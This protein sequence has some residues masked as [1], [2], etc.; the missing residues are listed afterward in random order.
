[1]KRIIDTRLPLIIY[2]PQ[3]KYEKDMFIN[4]HESG[5][6][7]VLDTEHCDPEKTKDIIRELDRENI[8]FGIRVLPENN[9]VL[10]FLNNNNIIHVNIVIIVYKN[11]GMPGNPAPDNSFYKRFLEISGK[12]NPEFIEKIKPHGLILK[13]NET[14]GSA[15]EHSSLS[16]TDWYI[17]NTG[18]PLFIHGVP[19]MHTTPGLFAAGAHGIVLDN[20]L[21]S[22]EYVHKLFTNTGTCLQTVDDHD[23]VDPAMISSVR[24]GKKISCTNKISTGNTFL[25][26]LE[27]NIEEMLNMTDRDIRGKEITFSGDILNKT[28]L[29]F[30]TGATSVLAQKGVNICI[31]PDHSDSNTP[32]EK[33]LKETKLT[34]Y[35]NLNE[36]EVFSNENNQI[37]D[38]IAVIGIAGIFPDARNIDE[39]WDNIISKKYSISEVPKERFDHDLYYSTDRKA[40]DKSYSKIGGVI[41]DYKF[42]HTKFGYSEEESKY[43]SRSQK[44]MLDIA[45]KAVEDAGYNKGNQLPK[46]RSSVI[47]AECLAA[48]FNDRHYKYA[49]PEIKYYLEQ[50]DEYNSLRTEEKQV[51]L[52]NLKK[53]T[54]P[55]NPDDKLENTVV[56][57]EAS[58]I[59][60]HLGIT[61]SAYTVNA[62][63]AS[64]L[65]AVENAVSMLL[66]GDSDIVIA[67]GINTS[68]SPEIFTGFSKM[69]GLSD[70]G[71]Y[72]FDERANGFV[73]GEGAGAVILKRMKDA[74]RDKD[75]I[76]GIIKGV[77]C[78][79]DGKGRA[80]AAPNSDGQALAM[81]RCFEKI[82]TDISYDDIDYIEAHG[83][84]TTAGDAEEIKTYKN[85]YKSNSPIGISSVKSQIG[86]LLGGAGMAG[87]IK[88]L[89]AM[90]NKTLPPNGVFEN[91]SGKIK[92]EEP[93]Y[94]IKDPL[95]W[96]KKSGQS[97]KASVSSFGFGGINTHIVI[98]E[99]T[100][101]YKLLKNKIFP[102]PGYD[103]NNDRIVVAGMGCVL[104]D[105]P[106]TESFFNNLITGKKSLYP[107]PDKKLHNKYYEKEEEKY[108]LPLLKAGII[109]DYNF[110]IKS[111]RIPP[112]SL[113]HID[114]YQLY[115][116]DAAAQA[117][118]QVKQDTLN[119]GNNIG[120]ITGST[121]CGD[122]MYENVLRTRLPHILKTISETKNVIPHDIIDNINT[123]LSISI[124]ERFHASTEDTFPGHITNLISGRIANTLNCNGANYAIDAAS[125]S[126]ACAISAAI[127]GLK[128]NDYEYVLTG[129]SDSNLTP[130]IFKGFD[131]WGILSH[132]ENR[133]FE[134]RSDGFSLGEGAVMFLLTK[135]KTARKN[136]MKIYAELNDIPFYNNPEKKQLLSPDRSS[137]RNAIKKYYSKNPVTEDQVQYIEVSGIS[138]I[139]FDQFEH[140]AINT[141]F[142]K[143]IYFGN[144]KPN[145]GYLKSANPAA[146]LLKLILMSHHAYIPPNDH[147]SGNDSILNS[148]SVLKINKEGI[149]L[150]KSLNRF[151]AAN[152]FGIGGSHAHCVV[153]NL[154]L[155]MEKYNDNIK[156]Q[157]IKISENMKK[158]EKANN[159]GTN[160]ELAVML[161]G[162]GAQYP[163]MMKDLYY[164]YD[165][166]HELFN[167][168]EKI[169]T[170]IT[171]YSLLDIMFGNDPGLILTKNTQPAVF[172]VSASLYSYLEQLG[173]A[174]ACFTGHS[175]G[176]FTALF[177]S[178]ML[179]FDRA[180]RLVIKR[181]ELMQKV[182]DE[183]PGSMLAIFK[184]ATETENIINSSGI[185]NIYPANKNSDNQTIVS[186]DNTSLARFANRLKRNN[187]LHSNINVATAFHSP[188][189]A[190]ATI[191]L[192][193]YLDSIRF[194]ISGSCK[195]YSNVTALPYPD[196]ENTVKDLLASQM[197]SPVEFCNTIKN[198]SQTGIRH[199]LEVGPNNILTGL[200]K[201]IDIPVDFS[202]H[203]I[204]SKNNE[205]ASFDDLIFS[206]KNEKLIIKTQ[207]PDSPDIPDIAAGSVTGYE[208]ESNYSDDPAG[209]EQAEYR[210]FI[211]EHKSEVNRILHDEYKKY[212]EK[213]EN[214]KC[215]KYGLY[216]GDIVI[217][218]VSAG[219]PGSKREVFSDH[220][221]KDILE[222]TNFIESVTEKDKNKILDKNITRLNKSS[223]GSARFEHVQSTDEVIQLAARLGY[224]DIKEYGIDYKYD[225]TYSLALAAGIEA[226]K[227][228][229]IPLVMQYRTATTGKTVQSGYALPEEMQE[230]TGIIFSSVF[231]G[232]DSLIEE[233]SKYYASKFLKEPF[234]EYEKLYFFLMEKIS[235]TDIKRTVTDWFMELKQ[236]TKEIEPYVFK[237]NL[238]IDLANIGGSILA[239]EIRA[240]GPVIHTSAA[241]ASATHAAGIAE[242]WIRTDRCDRV[243][244]IAGED[245]AS[246]N[247]FEWIGSTF[248]SMGIGTTSKDVREA[249]VPFD[250]RRKGTIIGSAG[251]ALIIE[252][253]SEV[254]KRGL[255]GQAMILG[256]YIGNSAFHAS[257]MDV[258]DI[259]KNMKL[260]IDKMEERHGLQKDKY[261]ESMLFMSHETYTPARGGSAISEVTA[262]KHAFPMHYK[263]ITITNTKGY[264]GHTIGAGIED[265]VM[266]KSLQMKQ[267]PAIANLKDIPAEFNDLKFSNGD[268][269]NYEYALHFAAGFGSHFSMLFVKKLQEAEIQDNKQYADWLRDISGNKIPELKIINKR[270]CVDHKENNVVIYEQDDLSLPENSFEK[271]PEDKAGEKGTI[272]GNTDQETALSTIKSIISELTGYSPDMLEEDLDLEADLGI[273][274]VKQV[275]IFGRISAQFNRDLPENLKLSEYN[276]IS[277]IAGF[278]ESNTTGTVEQQED[279][280]P[281]TPAEDNIINEIKAI[282]AELTGYSE[283][284]LEHDLDLEADLGIDTVKQ[285]EIFGRISA[286][287]NR[288]LPENL[289][290]SEYNT[291]SKIAGFINSNE[292][293]QD[294]TDVNEEVSETDPAGDAQPHIQKKTIKRAIPKLCE[295]HNTDTK[296]NIFNNKTFIISVDRYGFAKELEHQINENNGKTITIGTDIHC[297]HKVDLSSPMQTEKGIKDLINKGNDIHGFI[298]LAPVDLYFDNISTEDSINTAV[299]SFFVIVKALHEKLNNKDCLISALAFNS[300]IFPYSNDPSGIYPAYAGL[301]GMMKTIAKE[302]PEALVKIVDI[303]ETVSVE[304]IDIKK[305]ISTYILELM[306]GDRMVETGYDGDK[307]Y[308]ISYKEAVP[309]NSG[310]IIKDNDT[311]LVTGGARGITFEILRSLVN[312]YKIKLVIAGKTGIRGINGFSEEYSEKEIFEVLSNKMKGARPVEIK[313][314]VESVIKQRQVTSNIEYLKTSGNEVIYEQADVTNYNDIEN[315]ISRYDFNGIIHGAGIEESSLLQNKSVDS[316]NRVFDTKVTG[317]QNLLIALKNTE[318]RYFIAFSSVAAKFGNEGQADYSSSNDMMGKILQK[319]KVA[320]PDRIFKIIDWTAWEG[321]GMADRESVKKALKDK[322]I[323]FLS[324][325]QGVKFFMDEIKDTTTEEIVISDTDT[326]TD[327][328]G[329]FRDSIPEN[330]ENNKKYILLDE[331]VF[332][333][334]TCCESTYTFSLDKDLYLNSHIIGKYPVVP[335]TFIAEIMIE[336]CKSLLPSMN[337]VRLYDLEMYHFIKLF[338]NKNRKIKIIS[339]IHN[340][341]NHEIILH[342]KIMCDVI[343]HL[344]RI[345]QKDKLHYECK[346]ELSEKNQKSYTNKYENI[347]FSRYNNVSL[348][349]KSSIYC[350]EFLF[351]GHKMQTV[352]DLIY[353][354]RRMGIAEIRYTDQNIIQSAIDPDY[355]LDPILFDACLQLGGVVAG[356]FYKKTAL[357]AMIKNVRLY[358]KIDNNSSYYTVAILKSGGFDNNGLFTSDIILYNKNWEPV[359][360]IEDFIGREVENISEKSLKKISENIIYTK[361]SIPFSIEPETTIQKDNFSL[362]D[363]KIYQ[364]EQKV[365]YSRI[366]DIKHDFFLS[367][368]VKDGI[369]LF[370]G[371]TAIEAMTQAVITRIGNDYKI[372]EIHD[373]KIPYGIK[374]LKGKPKEI[375]IEA[376]KQDGRNHEFL[377]SISTENKHHN[378]SGIKNRLHYK[379]VFRFDKKRKKKRKYNIQEYNDIH[380]EGNLKNI[381][382][383]PELLFPGKT[384]QPV[385]DIISLNNNNITCVLCNKGNAKLFDGK[386]DPMLTDVVITDGIFQTCVLKEILLS[387]YMTLPVEISGF[388]YFGETYPGTKYYCISEKTGDNKET[389]EYRAKLV[390]P[391]KNLLIE[392]DK[393]VLIRISKIPDRYQISNKVRSYDK[394]SSMI[395]TI[396]Y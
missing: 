173:I 151:F 82:K 254:K 129:G 177:C 55:D 5:G 287:F 213:K 118:E 216:T 234:Q 348:F 19:G 12:L 223:D 69:G 52:N 178:G 297:D 303:K 241:C 188:L 72:P 373:F 92:L 20:S 261:T 395:N 272:P 119:Y 147:N 202:R 152:F 80:I 104:P 325:D 228:A 279:N 222:G 332:K 168:G 155:W 322:G 123:K 316:F 13:G 337:F 138:N 214:N 377:C 153:N 280:I 319:E 158:S 14:A 235:D 344:N 225:T 285:V 159:M 117:L 206:L 196:D 239:Q 132:G 34:L 56:S 171:G 85:I 29:N 26:D 16:L 244:V 58:G 275:E 258:E 321:T 367:D 289:K 356:L 252:K 381:I 313:N 314:A 245:A 262:L 57:Y 38:E 343:N 7:P 105:A 22:K 232:L 193:K 255:N 361:S 141:C 201:N 71:S 127:K 160:P 396:S 77:G 43:I 137:Y 248:L 101:D 182:A 326:D 30:I 67:G 164:Y 59:A 221:F 35:N 233:M 302:M 166:I 267:A 199:F 333:D 90:K 339:K 180:L 183:K 54:D 109:K 68:L 265:A 260:F 379:G 215:E 387:G 291:V 349:N 243:I 131:K 28:L 184:N 290:L 126:S 346:I 338:Y 312:K 50:I 283:D 47:I 198:I 374:I 300:V 270:L 271:E 150:D 176:E 124:K 89:L 10:D 21:F 91:V 32:I 236:N 87:M 46:D 259:S 384:F 306:S 6:L 350:A 148:S 93:F 81:K 156:N 142:G 237:K 212:K 274:T 64:S 366:L 210:K 96:E 167:R 60:N 62:A 74:I 360:L 200:I 220:N 209:Q 4:V 146:V 42:D 288:D 299:K 172:L 219:L 145:T 354:N 277:K 286:Q 17:E 368:H 36:L 207:I 112:N 122:N 100:A 335:V 257:R 63:C 192:R 249:A 205:T 44:M 45:V 341:N 163:G 217:S 318:Y 269:N 246:D 197:V 357:P 340:K 102:Y 250:T 329:P 266:I 33:I 84:S 263:N 372:S 65:I 226:L 320:D 253:E 75:K 351:M 364:D 113:K 41:S 355:S 187:I 204:D 385:E 278:V 130:S 345:T 116:L 25:K 27:T 140:Q 1:M 284:M 99:Y 251:T 293:K 83:T 331:T 190:D 121:M 211:T 110:N 98:E 273:D 276:T 125:V 310:E 181:A 134:K 369:P 311:I 175:L 49:Y 295:V 191:K 282:I 11:P 296:I 371:A 380:Y 161:S 307:K 362:L 15:S 154:P 394:K 247:Q 309:E 365:I 165:H 315:I 61:G 389:V 324:I 256:T 281:S 358:N 179:D 392:I 393:I 347:E 240:K 359:L 51:I 195:I 37:N 231:S 88:I 238:L 135:Y 149:R 268:T 352:N 336:N 391:D 376:R 94:I 86:H 107:L 53:A 383:H 139:L 264:S 298:H 40:E 390:N 301:S 95:P 189:F 370:L 230:R 194:N 218:G 328:C 227:D 308:H 224:F 388:R 353:L 9:E 242:D 382:Y 342:T 48:E 97:R 174:P 2:Y 133:F 330:S 66:S 31:D 78:S 334:D 8:L 157:T 128:S 115:A 111:C 208:T 169:F 386:K 162:Q 76:Y 144:I 294:V 23:P 3:K 114:K 304:N 120:V 305:T 229:H 136:N 39:F 323:S 186:G 363:K 317:V 79:S 103:F 327:P 24:T 70:D 18:Y 185:N 375:I 106:D 73:I 378:N 170:D 203:A 108:K 292:N 143:D